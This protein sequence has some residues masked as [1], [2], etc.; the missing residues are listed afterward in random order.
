MFI[1]FRKQH[2]QFNGGRFPMSIGDNNDYRVINFNDST[3]G[4]S[5]QRPQKENQSNHLVF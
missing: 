4:L 2:I 5:I 3:S 1:K